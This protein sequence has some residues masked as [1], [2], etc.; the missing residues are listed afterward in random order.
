MEKY[1]VK[2]YIYSNLNLAKIFVIDVTKD[3][4]TQPLIVKKILDRLKISKDGYCR[5]LLMS[6]I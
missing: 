1:I 6:N 3:S 2:I 5:T 4:F